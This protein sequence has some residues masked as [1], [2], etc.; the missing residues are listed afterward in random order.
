MQEWITFIGYLT[1]S[2]SWV[3]VIGVKRIVMGGKPQRHRID[4]TTVQM[5]IAEDKD[6][7][8]KG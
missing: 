3:L 8:T 4:I 7:T 2:G 6:V 1:S 5:E